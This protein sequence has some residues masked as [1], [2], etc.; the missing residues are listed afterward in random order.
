MKGFQIKS[1]HFVIAIGLFYIL[2]VIVADI[3]L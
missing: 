3:Q 1:W 2:T